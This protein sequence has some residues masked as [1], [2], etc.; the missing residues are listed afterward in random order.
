[1]AGAISN[2][3]SAFPSGVEIEDQ[4]QEGMTLRDYFA[5]HAPVSFEMACQCWGDHSP[6]TDDRARASFAAVWA[7][8]RYE[9]ADAMLAERNRAEGK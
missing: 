8:L 2:G 4:F 9:Y 1:M 3:G 7:L 6:Q 5:A